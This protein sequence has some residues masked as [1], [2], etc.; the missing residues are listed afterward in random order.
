VG[1]C[2]EAELGL[3]TSPFEV[4]RAQL[5]TAG[6]DSPVIRERTP[7]DIGIWR[8]IT[9]KIS[10]ELEQTHDS[11]EGQCR[12]TCTITQVSLCPSYRS[13]RN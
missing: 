9:V 6:V 12:S 5:E 13:D 7:T 4:F 1:V 2:E 11:L 8:P 10:A 3:L